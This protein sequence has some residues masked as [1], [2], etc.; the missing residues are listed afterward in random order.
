MKKINHC[1]NCF[2]L[3][4]QFSIRC[5]SCAAKERNKFYW[6]GHKKE[7]SYCKICGNKLSNKKYKL[8]R[9]CA[10][11]GH[12]VSNRVREIIRKVHLGKKVSSETKLKLSEQRKLD[13]NPNWIDGRSFEEYPTEFNETLKESIRKRDNYICQKCSVTEEE[14]L[15]VHGRVLDIHHIDYNKKNCNEENL[16]TLC[17]ECNLRVNYNRIYWQKYFELKIKS[18]FLERIK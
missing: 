4:W 10:L 11:I 18:I 7:V 6:K 13:K 1:I 15:I 2:K 12:K 8:C 14:H 5:K 9:S 3:I 16:I 17:Q